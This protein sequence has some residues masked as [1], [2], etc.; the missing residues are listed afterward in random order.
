[1]GSKNPIS[2]FRLQ[3]DYFDLE[4]LAHSHGWSNLAPFNWDDRRK[5]LSRYEN[6][7]GKIVHLNV[8]QSAGGASVTC[9]SSLALT[10][11]D[12]KVLRRR[13]AYM[14]GL[15]IELSEFIRRAKSLDR[16]I[17]RYARS[18]GARMLRS[19]TLFEDVVKTLFTTNASW[20][21]TKQMCQ[22][23][24]A[25]CAGKADQAGECSFFPSPQMVGSLGRAVL[26]K[27]CKLGYRAQYLK[28][29]TDTFLRDG[30]SLENAS[31]REVVERLSQVK[32]LGP[33]CANH[34][35]ILLG[36][37][38]QIPVDSE[39]RSYCREVGL[40]YKEETILKHYSRWHPF[41]FLAFRM[42]RRLGRMS[43]A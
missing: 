31:P 19:S 7:D 9:A 1:M 12:K 18:G 36:E 8:K 11:A 4:L 38:S 35:A 5:V 43:A 14:L 34:I 15:D 37:Y 21:F 6:V 3:A 42:E 23:L 2:R 28:N 26:T 22:R 41:E 29:I 40:S 27:E 13:S 17:H 32:G 25:Q 24:V 39:V 16:R 30:N 20:A 33:Y 10:A